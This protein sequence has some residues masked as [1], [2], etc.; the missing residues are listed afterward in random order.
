LPETKEVK[1]KN[2]QIIFMS[3]ALSAGVLL[4]WQFGAG[5]WD[6]Y[7]GTI[8]LI[9]G[10]LGLYFAYRFLLAFMGKKEILHEQNDFP[11]L[12]SLENPVVKGEI[13]LC[14][15]IPEPMIVRLFIRN[16]GN[17]K[18]LEVSNEH[19]GAGMHPQVFNTCLLENGV[20]YY[21]MVTNN[22]RTSRKMIIDN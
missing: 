4:L 15:T 10:L 18:Q 2:L 1:N 11:E 8:L 3:V 17:D 14:F 20:W 21:E 12:H 16:A 9:G 6:V 5:K 22:Y 19:F 13:Q 7:V